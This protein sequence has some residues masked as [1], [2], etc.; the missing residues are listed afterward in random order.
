[1]PP[2]KSISR[3]ALQRLR[4]AQARGRGP[5]QLL[6]QRE[7]PHRPLRAGGIGD[8]ADR[9]RQLRLRAVAIDEPKNLRPLHGQNL[10]VEVEADDVFRHVVEHALVVVEVSSTRTISRSLSA[11][12]PINRDHSEPSAAESC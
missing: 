10:A 3:D 12:M 11:F 5:L 2:E 9:R 6:G 4:D 8:P 7:R 1:M